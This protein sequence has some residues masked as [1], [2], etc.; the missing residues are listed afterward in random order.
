MRAEFGVGTS[1]AAAF[2]HPSR[3]LTIR[4]L[5]TDTANGRGRIGRC[6]Q[7]IIINGLCR[8][9]RIWRQSHCATCPGTLKHPP[10][11][12]SVDDLILMDALNSDSIIIH[13]TSYHP[14]SL[15]HYHSCYIRG[16][17]SQL[18]SASQQYDKDD[19][20]SASTDQKKVKK[21][22]LFGVCQNLRTSE[23]SSGRMAYRQ[24]P[25]LG[26]ALMSDGS[27]YRPPIIKNPALS[28]PVARIHRLI[29]HNKRRRG[30]TVE[31]LRR[32]RL[33]ESIR[34]IKTVK[35]RKHSQSQSKCVAIVKNRSR[36]I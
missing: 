25:A 7:P 23:K 13:E 5:R 19:E 1:V 24:G 16:A 33:P 15:P 29:H 2:S 27:V 22:F 10:R 17:N 14:A 34:W 28:P 12:I 21:T 8:G 35:K 31:T 18:A 20:S 4:L 30:W 3:Y 6:M 32:V 9:N 36:C 26:S 11:S